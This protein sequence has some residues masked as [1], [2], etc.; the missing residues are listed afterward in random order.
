MSICSFVVYRIRKV[1][2][3]PVEALQAWDCISYSVKWP[4]LVWKQRLLLASPGCNEVLELPL[5]LLEKQTVPCDGQMNWSG[6]V[7]GPASGAGNRHQFHRSDL[8]I[9]ESLCN[10][11]F[12]KHCGLNC[13][14]RSIRQHAMFVPHSSFIERLMTDVKPCL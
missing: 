13:P 4:S 12:L 2:L 7:R 14:P 11:P 5:S 9:L 3:A 8:G 1:K 6:V 10:A